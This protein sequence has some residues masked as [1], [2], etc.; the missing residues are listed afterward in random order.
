MRCGG[1]TEVWDRMDRR[2]HHA[3]AAFPRMRKRRHC[4][5]LPAGA[6]SS[7]LAGVL[8]ASTPA[9]VFS[10]RQ[11]RTGGRSSGARQLSGPPGARE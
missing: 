9:L 3:A 6:C 8:R 7:S 2:S 1:I 5:G 10:R 11:E 4:G